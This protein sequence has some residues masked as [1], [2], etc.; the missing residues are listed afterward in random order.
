MIGASTLAADDP[1]LTV[2]LP[3]LP[4][5]P[6]VR[7]AVAGRAMVAAGRRLFAS[8]DAG[9]VWLV[10]AEGTAPPRDLPAGVEIVGVA[11]GP[12]GRPDPRAMLLELGRRGLTRVLVEG[13]A[14]LAGAL[15][16][17]G[18]VDRIAWFRAPLALG[19]DGVSALEPLGIADPA[20]A[21]KW[22]RID[23]RRVGADQLETY[24]VLR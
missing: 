23:T 17:A 9:P 13:G 1:L 19:G 16:K 12:L 3:G 7:I 24:A 6:P 22:R 2:R 10:L 4:A 11:A 5:R 21:A 18:L 15:M 20:A 14:R 8:L